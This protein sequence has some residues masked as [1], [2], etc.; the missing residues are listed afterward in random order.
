[1]SFKDNVCTEEKETLC[2]ENFT[3]NTKSSECMKTCSGLTLT[4]FIKYPP[5]P[6][7]EQNLRTTIQQYIKYK[8]IFEVGSDH[9]GKR[10]QT[11]AIKYEWNIF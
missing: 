6:Q 1:M 3:E 4:S 5:N 11:I 2:I 10:S 7:F 9:K 8:N